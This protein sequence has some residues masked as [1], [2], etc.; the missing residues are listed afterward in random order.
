MDNKTLDE[1]KPIE[2]STNITF[3]NAFDAEFYLLLREIRFAMLSFMQ[4][5]TIQVESNILAAEGLKS[6][7]D[8]DKKKRKEDVPYSSHPT[9][10]DPKIEEMAKMLKTLTSEMARMKLETK[11]PNKHIQEGG[12]RNPNQF[13]RPQN[14]PRVMQRE[15]R[16]Q[17][18]QRILPPFQNNVVEETDE[19]DDIEENSTVLLID[20]E[21]P[22]THIT[23]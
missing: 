9:T 23:Q 12:N 11:K 3:G 7:F 5:E 4:K 18:D 20:I 14:D 19:S 15:R 2:T 17:E 16:N 8:K 10:F 1:I 13:K 6:K 21:L 22:S